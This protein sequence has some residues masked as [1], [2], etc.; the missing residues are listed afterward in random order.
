MQ[1]ALEGAWV[2]ASSSEGFVR[3]DV[4]FVKRL[5]H[6]GD[7]LGNIIPIIETHDYFVNYRTVELFKANG[8]TQ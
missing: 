5:L 2:G 8:V 4:I 6:G 1:S 7:F 3:I